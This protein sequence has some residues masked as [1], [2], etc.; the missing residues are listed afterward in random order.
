M[1]GR[2][3]KVT[4]YIK[5]LGRSVG[6]AAIDVIKEPTENITDFMETNEDLFKVVYSATKNYKQTLRTVDRSIK[7]SKI[8]EA[9]NAGFSAL[10]DD[11]KT[12]KFYNKEREDRFGLESFGDDFADFSEFESDNFD[13]SSVQSDEDIGTQNKPNP[14]IQAMGASS[15]NLSNAIISAARDQ[16]SVTIAATESI[17]NTNKASV[18]LLSAQNEKINAS[19]ITGFAGV[20][21]GLNLIST[22]MS[23]PL[24]NFMN[25]STKFYTDISAKIN[26][27]NAYLKELTEMQRNLYKQEREWKPGAF[28]EVSSASGMPNIT[29]YAKRVYKNILDMDPTGGM[30]MGDKDEN[31]LKAFVGSPLK[32]IP[33]MIAKMIIPATVSKTLQAF[34]ENMSGLF[35]AFITR[36]NT[37]AKGGSGAGGIDLRGIIGRIFGINLQR[38]TSIDTSKYTRGPI[39]FDGETKKAIVDVIPA[40]LARIE[41]AISGMP[42]RIYDGRSGTF[43]TVRQVHKEYRDIED[44]GV[45]EAL[46]S[47][48]DSFDR[49]A[50][51]R[52]QSYTVNGKS[53]SN[54]QKTAYYRDLEKKFKKMGQRIYRDGGDFQPYAGFGPKGERRLEEKL[55][56]GGLGQF[57]DDEWLSFM[58]YLNATNKRGIYNISRNTLSAIQRANRELQDA[59]GQFANP[60]NALFDGRLNVLDK[61]GR[62]KGFRADDSEY[63][64]LYKKNDRFKSATDYLKDILAEV[65]WIRMKGVRG[66]GRGGG[67]ANTATFQ[68][69]PNGKAMDTSKMTFEQYYEA[70]FADD[71]YEDEY[72]NQ[73][74]IAWQ[75]AS[76]QQQSELEKYGVTKENLKDLRAAQTISEKWKAAKRSVDRLLK[77]PAEW[78]TKVI[79]KA[80]QRIF[81]AMF[82]T[83]EGESFRDKHGLEYRGFLEYLVARAGEVFD[84]FKDKMKSTWQKFAEWFKKTKVGAWITEKGG[85]F[86]RDTKDALKRKFGYAKGAVRES[87][88]NTYGRI[89][90]SIRQ[91]RL[92]DASFVQTMRRQR[93]MGLDVHDAGDETTRIDDYDELT[94]L[95]QNMNQDDIANS[96]FGRVATKYGLTMLSPGEIV[97]PNRGY[98]RQMRNLA[99]EKREK[100]KIIRALKSGN[101]S[102]H[103]QGTGQARQGDDQSNM[104]AAVK[105][106][107]GEISGKGGDIAADAI[108]GSGVS[109]ITGIFGGPLLGAA[110]GA[111]IGLIKNSETIQ[112]ALFGEVGDDGKRKGG[113][114]PK[115]VI[116]KVTSFKDKNGKSMLNFGIAGGIAGLFT[117]LGLVGG[118]LAGS[119]FGYVKNTTWFQEMMFGNEATGKQGLMSKETKEK[120]QKAFPRMA[121]GAGAGI[122]LGP[123]GLVGNA[124][125]SA[126]AGYLTTS[127]KFREL[128][129]GKEGEDGKKHGGLAG[130]IKDGLVTPLSNIG[131][132][133]AS[134]LHGFAKKNIIDPMKEFIEGSGQFIRNIFLS[135]GDRVADGINGI[136]ERHVGLPFEEWIREKV[137]KRAAS[138]L[139]AV[140]KPVTGVAKAVVGAPFRALGQVGTT[141]KAGQIA[142][143]TMDTMTAAQRLEYRKKHKARF[144]RLG[145]TGRDKTKQ[146]DEMLAGADE[147][148][149]ES[150][151]ENIGT[152]LKN[153]GKHNVAYN[154]L[155]DQTGS[156]V[157][158]LFDANGIWASRGHAPIVNAANDKKAI[159]KAMY[160][161]DFDKVRKILKKLKLS[162]D[163]IAQFMSG[164]DTNAIASARAN[165]IQESGLDAEAIEKLEEA[166]GYTNLHKAGNRYVKQLGRLTSTELK[167]RKAEN[168]AKTPEEKQAEAQQETADT[169]KQMLKVLISINNSLNGVGRVLGE[170][171]EELPPDEA[172]DEQEDTRNTE[173][174]ESSSTS[175]VPDGDDKESVEARKKLSKKGKLQ[176]AIASG[177]SSISNKLTG[178]F[179]GKKEEDESPSLISKLF[180]FMGNA[181]KSVLGLIGGAATSKVGLIAAGVGAAALIGYGSEFVKDKLMPA[182]EKSPLFQKISGTLSEFWQNIKSGQFFVDMAGKLSQGLT[183]ALKNVAA[184]LTEAIIKALPGVI[185]GVVSGLFSGIKALLFGN[186]ENA[187][188]TDFSSGSDSYDLMSGFN[189]NLS[190]IPTGKDEDAIAANFNGGTTTSGGTLTIPSYRANLSKAA[191]DVLN[192]GRFANE[193][194]YSGA[195]DYAGAEPGTYENED[196]SSTVVDYSGKA[197]MYDANGKKLGSFDTSTGQITSGG[198][199]TTEKPGAL[200]TIKNAAVRGLATGKTPGVA[201]LLGNIGRKVASGKSIAKSATKVVTGGK[202]PLSILGRVGSA[203][204]TSVKG[205]IRT[206]TGATEAAGKA[207]ATINNLASGKTTSTKIMDK[208]ADVA[209]NIGDKISTGINNAGKKVSGVIEGAGKVGNKI[210]DVASSIVSK[211]TGK[212]TTNAASAAGKTAASAAAKTVS[213]AAN[214][215]AGKTADAAIGVAEK[216]ISFG[217]KLLN[218]DFFKGLLE[219]V[220]KFIKPIDQGVLKEAFEKLMKKIGENAAEK[221]GSKVASIALKAVGGL[222]PL[223]IITWSKAFYDGCWGKTE[224]ILGVTKDSGLE[225]TAGMRFITGLLNALNENLLLGLIP[226]D[227]LMEQIINLFGKVIGVTQ[228]E[229]KAA[230]TASDAI[231]SQ[232]SMDAGRNVTANE[233]NNQTSLWTKFKNWVTGKDTVTYKDYENDNKGKGRSISEIASKATSEVNT[234]AASRKAK[235]KKGKGRGGQQGGMYAAM[236]YGN[237]TIGQSGCAPV[238]AA[239]MIGSSI[240]EAARFAERTGHVS[241]DGSTDIGFFRDYFSAKG[242]SNRM[243]TD[244]GDVA[245]ALNSGKSAILLGRDP[246]GGYDSAY[247]NSSHFISARKGKNGKYIV[248]DPAIGVRQMPRSKVLK[249]MKASVI[250][251]RG[252]AFSGRSRWELEESRKAQKSLGMT[253][254]EKI[255]RVI[256]TARSQLGYK[257]GRNNDSKYGTEYGLPN[258][259]WCCM[260]VWWVFKYAGAS[261]LFYGGNKTASCSTLMGYYSQHGQIVT[262]AKKGDIIFMN[263][264]GKSSPGHVGI[265]IEDCNGGKVRTIEGN[266]SP[267]S[268]SG[269]Q[270]NG[271]GVYEKQRDWKYI[272]G[273][274]RPNYESATFD[275]AIPVGTYYNYSTGTISDTAPDEESENIFGKITTAAK[276]VVKDAF[277]EG[278]YNAVF[279]EDSEE[280][281]S[282]STNA[283]SIYSSPAFTGIGDVD[284]NVNSDG[285]LQGSS[286][287]EQ[288]WRYLRS[289]GYSREGTAGIM[290]NLQAESGLMPNNLQ[291]SYEK[292]LGYDDK[293]YTKAVNSGAYNSSQFQKDSAGYGLAQWTYHSRKKNLYDATVMKGRSVDSIK[294]QIDLLDREV[295][296]YG[297]GTALRSANSIN[298][299]S[300]LFLTDFEKPAK[301]N[302]S[303][304][305]SNAQAIY[306]KFK[307]IGRGYAGKVNSKYTNELAGMAR[308][309]VGNRT[310]IPGAGTASYTQFLQTIVSIL[311]SIA[312]NT[313]ALSKI[314]DILS[315]NFN[316]NVSS[317]EV[318][319]TAT[320][321]K[322]RAKEALSQLMNNKASAQDLSNILQTKD[323]SYLV[324]V[325]TSIARE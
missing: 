61:H 108:I 254:D 265:C 136:F 247:S 289:K 219:F 162:D 91:G 90:E 120:L 285:S 165:M 214:K 282:S 320:D 242:I 133:I 249:N 16:S 268:G 134:D 166:T 280:D 218:S 49:W 318:Q 100:N 184:P 27:T 273:V 216:I 109:L 272:V 146:L 248:N 73:A 230:K 271:E 143:G 132:K 13:F 55:Y 145:L 95:L 298:D 156:A 225:I 222:S 224:T 154:Q 179:G 208:V 89:A 267:S 138:A 195:S 128:L 87:W 131:K 103:A 44:R 302:Y 84:D 24:S 201:T 194:T 205:A 19:I 23:G 34:D 295:D 172:K 243:S 26:E 114:I 139:G 152:F 74:D 12:G 186:K 77:S 57:D 233:Y 122:L 153:R 88:D 256:S 5:N 51:E 215:A 188:Y 69:G 252:R 127:D 3:P 164:I 244:K 321:T 75:K 183:Y 259:A 264:D 185:T 209:L 180:N 274:A 192:N 48:Q 238:S 40:Y 203:I 260:F 175:E 21:A 125:L 94:D 234:D 270:D 39:P 163:D 197:T 32:A 308:D 278:L 150:M 255:D 312:D 80:D 116:E 187:E 123:F 110:A 177:I 63:K 111:G 198:G 60:L 319:K 290:G 294:D 97:I 286:T 38:K 171:G 25:E 81:D 22:I 284:S 126:G 257:E 232:A 46:S 4:E 161:G 207:G 66:S 276:M 30:L 64:G 151:S 37:W 176:A 70:N 2:L 149:L 204:S 144:A 235:N 58:A 155:M 52:A 191:Q 35:S 279:G 304:R 275:D 202:N 140:L 54:K 241:S 113:I 170:D 96:A 281:S 193:L 118:I 167:A 160:K 236:R 178:I 33:T 213:T 181:G 147:A 223:A 269:S 314:L 250:A 228:E 14:M 98:G 211:V 253:T 182:L 86:A 210:K 159:M 310:V 59:E 226:M 6:Y 8:Y 50:R 148:T 301:L 102:H 47:I 293:S 277:G 93:S 196:G 106:V 227:W 7:R 305:R 258:Q 325:M 124:L 79:S 45:T 85:Q 296:Q 29:A 173:D 36:M 189:S 292:K 104:M 311:L 20:N 43:K 206:V 78:A 119:T 82:G 221:A 251:G 217:T 10:K 199:I 306:N 299:A 316:I 117:P 101:I 28:D 315:K 115:S 303:A 99:G 200:N 67:R 322:K 129:L 323:T 15:S 121:I 287:A 229:Y 53:A 76:K 18:R 237:S 135:V 9:A 169:S 68:V 142:R 62:L 141:L 239:N 300:D 92:V 56:S 83:P 309:D 246:G 1:A 168:A 41:S 137:F 158:D 190:K 112:K 42:E 212:T 288:I 240:P 105:K 72:L 317:E 130:A 157:S 174:T 245:S 266:T 220:N 297:L 313:E 263:F 261:D 231:L 107:M 291:N 71:T 31:L 324:D 307:G 17:I 65:R 11:I 283:T 262:N